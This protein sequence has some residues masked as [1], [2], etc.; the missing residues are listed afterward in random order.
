[1][2]KTETDTR[3]ERLKTEL[4]RVIALCRAGDEDA[5]HDLLDLVAP[6]I[7]AIC[8]RCGLSREESF[9]IFGQ[10]CLEFLKNFDSLRAPE[11]LLSFV[12]TITRRQVYSLFKRLRL[13]EYLDDEG[14][15]TLPD[16]GDSSPESEYEHI[17]KRELLLEA[18]LK[19]PL[20]DFQLIKAL[21]LDPA[22]PSYEEISERL[23]LPVSSI[24]PTRARA[25]AKLERILRS[26]RLDF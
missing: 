20:R 14:I 1:M 9:D 8:K 13:L 6:V 3:R 16:R 25:L 23:N 26:R 15:Q 2:S 24:G 19:L 7:F 18:M 5:W 11:K 22:E 21:F 17:R 12:A 10:V 4:P